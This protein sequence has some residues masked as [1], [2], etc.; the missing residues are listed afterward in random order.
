MLHL[1]VQSKNIEGGSRS[2]LRRVVKLKMVQRSLL[3]RVTKSKMVSG[4]LKICEFSGASMDIL[5]SI[6]TCLPFFN[7]Y[8]LPLVFAL[9]FH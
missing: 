8:C 2:T 3:G 1:L 4:L 6:L 9:V 7:R 5:R